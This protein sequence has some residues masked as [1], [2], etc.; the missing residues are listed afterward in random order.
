MKISFDLRFAHLPGGGR[1]YVR[2]LITTLPLEY[3]DN[4][5]VLYHN[6][7][8]PHQQ[9][10]IRGL[11]SL[12]PPECQGNIELR[13]VRAPILSL[14]HH[15]EFLRFQD[16]SELYHYPHFDL[17]LGLRR[18]PIVITLH[19]LYP[20]SDSGYCSAVKRAYFYRLTRQA[21]RRAKRVIA[22]SEYTKNE[23]VRLLEVPAEKIA[24][25]PQSH[26][27]AHHPIDDTDLLSRIREKYNLSEHFIFYTGNHKPH[28][29][30][31][32]LFNSYARLP[33]E[34]RK[35]YP[36]ILAG[37]L[38]PQ[39]NQLVSRAAE[40]G[41]KKNVTFLGWVAADDLPALYNLASLVVLPSLYEGFGCAAV[42]AMACGTAVACSNGGA[43]PEVAGTTVRFFDPYSEEDMTAALA[44]SLANDVDN[45]QVREAGIRRAEQFSI[46]KTA[47]LTYKV[48]QEAMKNEL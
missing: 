13:S 30:L 3:P 25:V 8:C 45:P 29:N 44:M 38:S 16:T 4:H 27:P 17:P 21:V 15:I 19:D 34:L 10:I 18:V 28:K 14:R 26:D 43:I 48:Y 6:R 23:A 46:Y 5:W 40:L 24:V 22:I 7:W 37:K 32:R 39:T 36:L 2:R 31:V 11:Y 42:E 9:E 12:V 47:R 1:V 20:L 33:G 35:A 41:I